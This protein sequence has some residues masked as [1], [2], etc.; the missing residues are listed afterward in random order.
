MIFDPFC[1]CGTTI[2]ATQE[3]GQRTWIGCDVAILAIKIIREI[4]TERTVSSEGTDFNVDGIPPSVEAATELF[5][6]DAH[7]FQHWAVER[8][9]GFPMKKKGADRGIDGRIYFE[10]KQGL[11][12]MVLS[13]KGGNTG[14][15][16][17]RDLAGVIGS[18]PDSELGGFIC[19][20]EPTKA[21]HA[22][23]AKAG[24]FTYQDV[25]YPRVQILSIS[26]IL[27]GKREFVLRQRSISNIHRANHVTDLPVAF[28]FRAFG[29]RVFFGAGFTCNMPRYGFL[30]VQR[31]RR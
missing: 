24:M 27:E 26:E 1:G 12:C 9:G 6:R 8:V 4:L 11:R 21:M 5:N 13:V 31:D 19:L 17:V 29:A 20:H 23:A 28:R 22:A 16:D 3:V 14:P 15:A 30:E 2:Y 7:Q 25:E 18:E 10:A